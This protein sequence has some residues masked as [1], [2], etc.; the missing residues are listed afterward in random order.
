M[1]HFFHDPGPAA[2][3]RKVCLATTAYDSPD[4]SY[5]FSIQA[6]REALT[7]AGV[8]SAYMLLSGNCHVDD[9][10]NVIVRHFLP[11]DCTDLLFIDA[12]VSWRPEDLVRLCRHDFDLIGSV[13]PY[14]RDG[15]TAD[16]PIRYIPGIKPDENGLLEVEGLPTGFMR[17]NRFILETMAKTADHCGEGDLRTPLL[18]ERV[19]EDTK[20]WGGDL[21]F[22]NKWRALGGKVFCDVEIRLGH[23]A[24]VIRVDSVGASLRRL[25]G[26]TLAYAAHMIREGQ[27]DEA[28]YQEAISYVSNPFGAQEPFLRA[29]VRHARA[30]DGP[31]IETGTGLS[32]ILMAAATDQPLYCLED[33][34][35]WTAHL[36]CLIARADVRGIGLC[37]APLSDGWYDLAGYPDLPERF[38]LGVNDGP[39]RHRGDRMKFFDALGPRC[40]V[41]LVDDMNEPGYA[42]AVR[43]WCDSHGRILN[44]IDPRAAVIRRRDAG[45]QAA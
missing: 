22:C 34:P 13:Y 19:T 31:I 28:V 16:M 38:A 18:F 8:P 4:A 1:S 3:G 25:A 36:E 42:E 14:R 29:L 40:D 37:E 7:K 6:S 32:T 44:F 11:T 15:A 39:A 5:T 43:Q 12:D 41:I 24:K 21:N 23:V 20:R 10:R 27:E 26:T 45:Q 2:A 9:A 33:D 30:V 17:I 35:R